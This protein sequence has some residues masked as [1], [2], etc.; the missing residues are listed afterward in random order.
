MAKG[1]QR[2]CLSLTTQERQFLGALLLKVEWEKHHGKV[3]LEIYNA[4]MDAGLDTET[5]DQDF[6]VEWDSDQIVVT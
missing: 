2:T 1:Y 3:A 5:V 6:V 4:L